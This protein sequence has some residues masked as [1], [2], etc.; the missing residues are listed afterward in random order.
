MLAEADAWALTIA[1]ATAINKST[2][3]TGRIR[4][5]KRK[6]APLGGGIIDMVNHLV[7]LFEKQNL[8]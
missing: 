6:F 2:A 7:M 4:Q 1:G 8:L 3:A 5:R